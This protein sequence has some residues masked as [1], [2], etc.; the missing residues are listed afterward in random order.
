MGG[1]GPA[2]APLAHDHIEHAPLQQGGRNAASRRFYFRKL[3]H[4]LS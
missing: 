3:G 4:G 2:Q 1:D